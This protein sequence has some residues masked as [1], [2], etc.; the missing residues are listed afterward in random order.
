MAAN[1][2]TLG[3]LH[4]LTAKALMAKLEGIPVLNED[5]EPTGEVI[6]CSAADIQAAAKFL[7]D[8]NITCVP[9]DDNKLGE[10][11]SQLKAKQAR[12]ASRLTP[13][14]L[15]DAKEQMAFTAGLPN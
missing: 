7:K 2:T 9:A 10:L 4:D 5:G 15:A 14:D 12:R 11:E 3:I 8:N 6:P 1:E 13:Q